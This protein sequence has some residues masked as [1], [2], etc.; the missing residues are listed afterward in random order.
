IS[1]EMA[2]L[3]EEQVGSHMAGWFS[4]QPLYDFITREQPELFH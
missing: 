4:F 3:T 1:P 2:A